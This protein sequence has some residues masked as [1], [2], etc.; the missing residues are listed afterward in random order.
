MWADYG[1][2]I[3][4]FLREKHFVLHRTDFGYAAIKGNWKPSQSIEK[5]NIC[6][7][8]LDLRGKVLH[9][10]VLIIEREIGI[11][12]HQEADQ[13]VIKN[14]GDTAITQTLH[15]GYTRFPPRMAGYSLDRGWYFFHG[16]KVEKGTGL[17]YLATALKPEFVDGNS[18][19]MPKNT[20]QPG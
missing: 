4:E 3:E 5:I 13:E 16:F 7:L 11:R 1:P 9:E 17:L 10:R 14:I 20:Y 15:E 8:E 2:K 6:D 19:K 18:F 12:S